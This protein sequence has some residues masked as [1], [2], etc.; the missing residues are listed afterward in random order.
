MNEP[1][2]SHF[3]SI[4]LRAVG[5]LF[6][7]LY[8]RG[9]AW[10]P[11][12]PLLE[13]ALKPHLAYM[14]NLFD[15]GRLVFA[16]PFLD[17]SGG[18]AFLHAS[19]EAEVAKVRDDDPAVQSGVFIG[20]VK[21]WMAVFGT[22]RDL[23]AKLDL[24]LESE[25]NAAVARNLF[26]AIE[27]RDGEGV[28]QAYDKAITIHEAPSL[29][30]GGDYDGLRG[31]FDHAVGYQGAWDPLQENAERELQAEVIAGGDRVVV[32]WKQR[33]RNRQS[34][35]TFEM[36]VASVYHMKD[37]RIVDSRMFHFDAGAS[38]AFLDRAT[39]AITE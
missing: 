36:A 8:R 17:E 38:R 23:S 28:M 14:Q 25:R 1:H 19:D 10:I 9:P 12:K 32:L 22:S 29:P 24:Q 2:A 26:R 27:R 11:G 6:A 20:E 34:G 16:G 33:G 3:A 31:A 18:L 21:V 5:R 37:G 39:G 4:D 13:Q 7:I 15:S 35:E 30:Y